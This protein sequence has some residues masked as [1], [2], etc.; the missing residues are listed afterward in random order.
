MTKLA[1]SAKAA[2]ERRRFQLTS[3]GVGRARKPRVL[4]TSGFVFT[5]NVL[6]SMLSNPRKAWTAREL[7]AKVEGWHPIDVFVKSVL[8]SLTRGGYLKEVKQ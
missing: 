6:V 4:L 1:P 2:Y 8:L 7:K 5:N 3:K